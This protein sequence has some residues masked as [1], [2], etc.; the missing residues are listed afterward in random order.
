MHKNTMA[1]MVTA[2]SSLTSDD[3]KKRMGVSG[4]FTILHSVCWQC[5]RDRHVMMK[6]AL[7][8]QTD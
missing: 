8:K 7:G 6:E 4:G 3:E 1:C 2:S 5:V